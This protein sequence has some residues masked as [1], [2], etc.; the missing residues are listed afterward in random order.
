MDSLYW[1]HNMT[2]DKAYIIRMKDHE[3]SE[4]LAERCAESCMNVGQRFEFWDAYNGIENP[5]VS[6]GHYNDV[7][8]LIK[9]T[10]HYLTRGEV[11]C[12]LSHISLWTHCVTIDRPIVILEHDAIML[13]P[14]TAHGVYNSVAYLGG[15]EQYQ[16][17]WNVTS[18]PPHASDGPNY[19]FIC[20]AHAYAI[21]P[22]VAKNMLA[23]VIKMGICASLDILIRADIFAIHQMGLYAYDLDDETTILERSKEGRTTQRNDNLEC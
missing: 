19:H 6:P 8:K 10:D 3:L 2:V 9:I 20:R 1:N 18:I 17:A 11:A 13:K 14:Y 12:A 7:M 15:R 22:A 4:K 5:I 21:D 16:H 23:H